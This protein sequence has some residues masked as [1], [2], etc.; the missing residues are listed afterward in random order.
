MPLTVYTFNR[1]QFDKL[2][3]VFLA[4]KDVVCIISTHNNY[5]PQIDYKHLKLEFNHFEP[6]SNFQAF[7]FNTPLVH[8]L[9]FFL[10]MRNPCAGTTITKGLVKKLKR[11]LSLKKDVVIINETGKARG[12]T[13]ACFLKHHF[14]FYYYEE[15]KDGTLFLQ[16]N[17]L[18]LKVFKPQK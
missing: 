1:Q 4:G 2:D 8:L 16:F 3:Q 5:L 10:R 9:I 14:G 7:I 18:L 11:Y 13:L 15:P 17:Q 6:P 12:Y